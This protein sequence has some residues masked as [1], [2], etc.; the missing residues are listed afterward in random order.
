MLAKEHCLHLSHH[1]LAKLPEPT[2]LDLVNLVKTDQPIRLG[3]QLGLEGNDLALVKR[4]HPTDHAQQLEDVLLLYMKQ[5]EKP[6]W[7]KV[8]TALWN[9][10][11]KRIAK[12]ILDDVA[13]L[14]YGCHGMAISM[15]ISMHHISYMKY[16]F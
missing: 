11:E 13:E 6:S 9:I 1:S 4:N 14:Q 2:L 3:L 12:K 16:D 5:P 10:G 15:W 7:K 8:T